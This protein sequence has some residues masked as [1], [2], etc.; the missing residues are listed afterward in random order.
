METFTRE[1]F[2]A[3]LSAAAGQ[4]PRETH[5]IPELGGAVVIRAMT[6]KE[7]DQVLDR[8]RIKKG[9]RRGDIDLPVFRTQVLLICVLGADGAPLLQPADVPLLSEL[10]PKVLD[11]LMGVV[12]RLSGFGADEEEALG[13]AS[14]SE[15]AS[16]G[17]A[18]SSPSN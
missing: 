4:L 3:K 9:P 15:A 1:A 7:R 10:T 2:L 18:S 6:A 12:N 11:G 5:Q 17:S 14:A 16:G 13:N 8:A